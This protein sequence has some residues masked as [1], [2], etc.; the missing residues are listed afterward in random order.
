[1][2]VF[3]FDTQTY[4]INDAPWAISDAPRFPHRGLMIDSARHFETL[5]S[6]KIVIDSLPFAKLNV[7][8]WHMSDSQSYPFQVI[9]YPKLWNAAWSEQEKFTQADVRSVVEYARLRGVRVIV[10]F[11]IGDFDSVWVR[12]RFRFKT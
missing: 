7:L 5:S 11:D 8:H 12:H 3:D 1:M 4:T 9:S 2:V 10:E 6:I